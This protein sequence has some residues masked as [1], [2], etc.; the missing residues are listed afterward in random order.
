MIKRGRAISLFTAASA[1]L[2]M[3]VSA[4]LSLSNTDTAPPAP[5]PASAGA[6]AEYS[7]YTVGEE[8]GMV[9]VFSGSDGSLIE[10]TDYPVAA[11]PIADREA[12]SIGIPIDS[13][14]EL[15]MLMEDYQ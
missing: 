5:L 13:D 15:A 9:A 8:N 10:L 3:T 7:L 14:E 1:A 11:L 2:I 6:P 4:A 12:L